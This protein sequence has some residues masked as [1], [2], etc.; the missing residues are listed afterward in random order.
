M[1]RIDTAMAVSDLVEGLLGQI[2][3]TWYAGRAR[4]YK[5]D[6][7]AL[8]KGIARYGHECARRGWE[9][10]AQA[11]Y[12]D[13]L[14][15]LRKMTRQEIGYLPV[16]LEAAIDQ[17]VRERAEELRA[18]AAQPGRGAMRIA[19]GVQRVEVIR[20]AGVV[21]TLAEIY[22]DL[23]KRPKP[24]KKSTPTKQLELC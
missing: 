6:E 20:V 2:R 22:K 5:R 4:E 10:E 15:M 23:R 7:R 18:A 3:T 1:S 17:H 24:N 16:Y 12:D 14:P 11:I 13:I 21:E 9:F 19:E 8:L